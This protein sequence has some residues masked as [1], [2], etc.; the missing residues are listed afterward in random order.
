MAVPPRT[1]LPRFRAVLWLSWVGVR[2][3]IIVSVAVVVPLALFASDETAL[4]CEGAAW[5][6]KSTEGAQTETEAAAGLTAE[7]LTWIA[8]QSDLKVEAV[9]ADP[10]SIRF[11]QVG[12]EVHYEGGDIQV[13]ARL[14]GAYD[15]EHNVIYLVS[16]WSGAEILDRSVLLHELVHATQLQGPPPECDAALEW[17]AYRLQEAYL[18]EHGIDPGFDWFAIHMLSRCPEDVHP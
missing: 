10:P 5:E 18:A 2:R 6:P 16:P 9:L 7:L 12:E 13:H 15:V 3:S 17:E 8:A 11:C 1:R 14:K 4:R